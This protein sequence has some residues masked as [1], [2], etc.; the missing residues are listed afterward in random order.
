M[1][2]KEKNA[3]FD[4]TKN[5][6]F[7]GSIDKLQDW[8]D[9]EISQAKIIEKVKMTLK[10]YMELDNVSFLFGSGTSIH[11]GQFLLETFLLKLKN[12]L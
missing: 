1:E 3:I 4:I 10:N 5:R 8:N 11:L 9:G 2:E 6:V 7:F 12:I